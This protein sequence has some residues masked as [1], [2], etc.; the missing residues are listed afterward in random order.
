MLSFLDP[1]QELIFE[2]DDLIFGRRKVDYS[3]AQNMLT[4]P[5]IGGTLIAIFFVSITFFTN[6][7]QSHVMQMCYCLLGAVISLNMLFYSLHIIM[8]WGIFSKIGYII[9]CGIISSFF[10]ILSFVLMT[11]FLLIL[12]VIFALR[13]L[14][15][16]ASD[17][18]SRSSGS[19]GGS[20]CDFGGGSDGGT[21]IRR[22]QKGYDL[23][24]GD[25]VEFS[26]LTGNYVSTNPLFPK[27]YEKNGNTFT[28]L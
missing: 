28:E 27:E 5:V 12:I 26:P 4:L 6:I 17:D 2:L 8:M 22:E 10:T 11:F 14:M 3:P 7:H 16:A 9:F 15:S 1:L 25:S 24:N 19:S 21:F 23:E 18:S 20:F 13:V